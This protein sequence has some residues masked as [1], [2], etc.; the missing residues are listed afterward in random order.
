MWFQ[1]EIIRESKSLSLDKGYFSIPREITWDTSHGDK[2]YGYFYPATN[3][4][5]QAPEDH[6]PPLLVKAHGG[7]TTCTKDVLNLKIQ[8]FT[9]RGFAVLDVNYRGSTGYGRKYRMKLRG[10]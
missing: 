9:S 4:D 7:P 8:Y 6:L 5:Y 10:Q 3:K 1:P 2:A